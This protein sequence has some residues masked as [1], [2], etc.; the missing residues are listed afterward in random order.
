MQKLD[1]KLITGVT[2]VT[3]KRSKNVLFVM[4]KP[5]VF[6]S[7]ASDTYIIFGEM[8]IEDLSSQLQTKAAEKF[9]AAPHAHE[10]PKGET[11]TVYDVDESEEIDETG[12]EPK[13]IELVMIQAC[14]SRS[15]AVRAL[16]NANNDLVSAIMD[17]T[18]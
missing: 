15:M 7:P 4:S 10:T 2:R 17:L 18:N 12:I 16:R 5:D 9:K 3:M 6:K 14:V 8:K 13:D 1:M 11:S